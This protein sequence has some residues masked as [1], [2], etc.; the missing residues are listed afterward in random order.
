MARR[1]ISAY[2]QSGVIPYRRQGNQL[3]VL[4]ITSR[5]GKRWVIPKGTVATGESPRDSAQREAM[6]EAGVRGYVYGSRIGDYTYRKWGGICEVEVFLMRVE[7]AVEHWPEGQIRQ[8]RWMTVSEAEQHVEE[9]PLRK[10][11][12]NLQTLPGEHHGAGRRTLTA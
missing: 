8:R 3:E 1:P 12:L 2:R 9:I 4:L 7:D 5:S 6:E 11:I 10:M